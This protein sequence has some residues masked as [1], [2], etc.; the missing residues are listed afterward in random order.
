MPTAEPARSVNHSASLQSS[1]IKEGDAS[2]TGI[3]PTNT[4]KRIVHGIEV[5]QQ[6]VYQGWEPGKEYT[7]NIVLKNVSVKT[8]KIKF[9]APKTRF[10]T[11][12]YPKP[13]SLS[14]GTSFTLPITFRPLERVR[15]QDGI[16]FTSKEGEFVV[17]VQ[18]VLPKTVISVP[19]T[20]DFMMCAA[21]DTA[22]VTFNVINTGDLDTT[23]EWK[24][25]EPFTIEPSEAFLK[26]R[27]TCQ[28]TATFIPEMATVYELEAVCL[29]GMEKKQ[30][31][32]VTMKGIGKYPH[33][34]VSASGK[35]SSNLG[36]DNLEAVIN[37]GPVPVGSKNTKWVELYNLSPVRA[38]FRVDHA[39]GLNYIDRV[40]AI[41]EQNGIVPANSSIRIPINFS[42]NTVDTTSIDYF[43]VEA[44]GNI[45]KSVIKCMGSS[46]GPVVQLSTGSINFMQ[47][48]NGETATRTVEVINN[49]DVDAV[50]QFVIDCEESVFTFQQVSGVVKADSRVVLP[51]RFT[52]SAPINF[53]RRVTCLVHNQGPLYLDLM[54]TCHTETVKPAVLLSRHVKRYHTHVARGFSLYPPEQLNELVEEKKLQVDAD[55]CLVSPQDEN[56]AVPAELP[57]FEEYFNDGFHSD[58]ISTVPHVSA[59]IHVADFGHCQNLQ[60]NEEKTINITNHTRG[61]VLVHWNTC[62]DHVFTILQPTMEIPPLKTCSFRVRFQPRAPNKLYGAEL[63]CYVYYKSLRDYRLVQD[64]THCPPWCLTLTCSG[65][66]FQPNN[67]TF[68]PQYQLDTHRVV[69]PAVN[70]KESTYRT[71]LVTNTGTTPIMYDLAKDAE[72]IFAIKPNRGLLATQH[73]IFV[74]RIIPEKV[75]TYK[76]KMVMRLNDNDKYDKTLQL[77]GSAESPEVLLDCEGCMF[78]K[79]TCIGTASQKSYTIKNISRIPLRY[80]WRMKHTDAKQLKVAPDCGLIPPNES[81]SQTWSFTPC[82]QGK[83]V[84]KPSLIVWGQGFSSNTSG[85]KKKEFPVRVVAEGALGSIVAEQTYFE[86]GDVVVGSSAT[87]H[88]TLFNNSSCALMYRLHIDLQVEGPSSE[89]ILRDNRPGLELDTMSGTIPARSKRVII[90][91]VRP[92]RRV[93]YQYSVSYQLLTPEANVSDFAAHELQ[94]LFHILTTGVYPTVAVTDARCAG[95]LVSI[96]KKHLWSLFSLDSLNECLD[97]DPSAEELMYHT[98]TRHSHRRRISVYTRAILD[99]NFSAAPLGSEP[100][101]V[102]LMFENTGTVATEWAFLFPCDLQL[103]LEYWAETG[104]FDEDEL[105][106]MKVMDNKL[107]D[108]TPRKG[109]LEPGATQTVTLTYHHTMAGTDRL[110]VLL[111]IAR[112]RE[113]LLNFVGVTVEPDRKYIHFPSKKHMFTPVPVGEKTSP[114]QVYELYNGGAVPVYYELDLT[115]LDI[116]QKENYDQP[117]FECLNPVGEIAPGRS[118]SIE[119]RFSPLEAKT[120]MVDVPILV[121][122]GESAIVTFTGIGYD[123]RIMGDTM[124]L[125]ETQDMSGVPSVQSIALPGQLSQL[126]V[127]RMSFGNMPLFSQARRMVFVINRSK[128]RPISFQWHVTSQADSQVLSISPIKGVVPP[129]GDAMCR[130]TFLAKGLPSFYDLDIICEVMDEYEMKKYK[131]NLKAWEAERQRQMVEFTITEHDLDADK[132]LPSAVEVVD[133]PPSGRLASLDSARRSSSSAELS[134]YK[135]LPPIQVPSA[136]EE[137]A[138]Q[139]ASQKKD[140]SLWAKPSPPSPFLLHL[141]LTARTHDIAHFQENFA[142]EYAHYYIDRALSEK[143]ES[144][145][146]GS[147]S[148]NTSAQVVPTSIS[149]VQSEAHIISSVLSNVLRGLLDDSYF[150]DSVKKVMKEPV[151]YFVQYTPP[152]K[153]IT[154]SEAGSEEPADRAQSSEHIDTPVSGGV[155]QPA[156]QESVEVVVT[157][158]SAAEKLMEMDSPRSTT[159]SERELAAITHSPKETPMTSPPPIAIRQVSA[160]TQQR[161]LALEVEKQKEQQTLKKLPEFGNLVESVLENTMLNILNEAL[162]GDYNI[163][164][165]RRYIA[166]PKYDPSTA[167]TSKRNGK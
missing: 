93:T 76:H 19:D 94:H 3:S 167:S 108:V 32:T 23:V 111:K 84:M 50:F 152:V 36:R 143:C 122:N 127:E 73:Q 130:I 72:N 29:F 125:N 90:A 99:F 78:F 156:Q 141:G 142:V 159:S 145:S 95:S 96:S 137:L 92:V 161:E 54:G 25:K 44:I 164:A 97:S 155:L 102:S 9:S 67:E 91:T 126:S 87:R 46:K 160:K 88:I 57:P 153:S 55:G 154:S 66:T 80:E 60:A 86:F 6:I 77:F 104:E 63:E 59:D 20:L 158:T 103:E 51:I 39:G 129:D 117:I 45:S 13:L 118:V 132:R 53:Y 2:P 151:P 114:K 52:P 147:G 109:K 107:F 11:T 28:F 31:V 144:T 101:S 119:W 85:G 136:D 146:S 42:P 4:D 15:Y 138:M 139:R 133:R 24:T 22:T 40:F 82:E 162:A 12:L 38:P 106:E 37:F 150:A 74:V 58:V 61:K 14:A 135:T 68:L 27:A 18:A 62:P 157:P 71:V 8:Q 33:L 112:G 1:S 89:E 43:Y 100:C 75:Q 148:G 124:P 34:L 79:P 113:I 70:T 134:R 123:R 5:A 48:D 81:Q 128:T 149:C 10:F 21:R 121:H 163:T 115:P 105:H 35:P 98:A 140:D 49:S 7:K 131:K 16:S 41:P 26:Y 110:P 166:M 69:F 17:P 56:P 120:Y 30:C 83:F 47:I 165:R 116:I 64:I 65:Q